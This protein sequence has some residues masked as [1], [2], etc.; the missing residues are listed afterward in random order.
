M[1]TGAKL[2]AGGSVTDPYRRKK[3]VSQSPQFVKL[4]TRRN[5]VVYVKRS[6]EKSRSSIYTHTHK[7]IIC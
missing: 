1:V 2:H 3:N 6:E 7:K 4:E 5:C